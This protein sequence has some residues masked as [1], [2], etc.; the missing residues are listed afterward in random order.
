M[1]AWSRGL[2]WW[3]FTICPTQRFHSIIH[4]SL[5]REAKL[6]LFDIF[7][8]GK[9]L[10]GTAKAVR[11]QRSLGRELAELPMPEFVP[12]CIRNLN[13]SAGNWEGRSR[14]PNPSAASLAKER[15]LPDELAEFYAE[16]DGFEPVHGEFPAAV[17]KLTDLRLG[18]SYTPSLAE[19]LA[20]FWME[21]GNDSE[22]PGMLSILPPDN[23]AALATHSADCYLRPS[24]LEFALPLC[25][26]SGNDFV[27]LLLADAGE[28]L[29]RGT[30]LEVEG[31]SA[32]R[33]PGFKAWLG[34]RASLFG[35]MAERF[36][37]A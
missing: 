20:T 1:R 17:L 32:T 7:R 10:V 15:K 25:E 19:R 5:L 9:V 34:T 16:C 4:N 14:P 28:N 26:P 23:L 37:A 2:T 18:S 31:G 33:Y 22:K 8:V 11:E 36:G 3:S 12:E 35:S 30:V 27:V 21:C 24:S 13:K 29:P 6:G